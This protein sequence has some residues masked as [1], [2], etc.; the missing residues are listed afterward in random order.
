[1]TGDYSTPEFRAR[2]AEQARDAANRCDLIVTVSAFTAEQVISLLGV[3]WARVRVIHHGI[4]PLASLPVPREPMVLFV[5]AVQRRKNVVRLVAAFEALPPEW[6]LVLA[7]ASGFGSEE[8]L[9]RIQASPARDRI[10]VKGYV[11]SDELALLYSKA[12]IFAF[13]S[14]DEGFGMPVLEAMAHDVPVLASNR[15]ALP[16]VCGDASLLVDPGS[17][18]E[19]ADGLLRLAR[20]QALRETLMAR[21]RQRHLQFTWAR[22]VSETWSVYRELGAA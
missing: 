10:D 6:R 2:F 1:M 18:D 19:I 22:A 16:E 4:R 21:G 14:L 15:S 5:G 12:S 13:P 20:D 3:E 11:E 9:A 8:A 7:G 17:A